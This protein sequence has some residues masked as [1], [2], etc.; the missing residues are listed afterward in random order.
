MTVV[1]WNGGKKDRWRKTKHVVPHGDARRGRRFFRKPIKKVLIPEENK[2]DLSEIDKDITN[3]V[4]IIS[5]NDAKSILE[6]SL[7]KTITPLNL[8]ESDIIKSHG[9][10]IMLEKSKMEGLRVK[11]FLP[12]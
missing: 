2:K 12:V 4:K 11:I 8:S 3:S 7:V 10:N 9:G 5:V 6:H 1:C